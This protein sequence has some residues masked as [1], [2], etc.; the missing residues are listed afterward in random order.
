LPQ[1][2]DCTHCHAIDG[3]TQDATYTDLDAARFVSDFVP[4]SKPQCTECHTAQAA[5]NACQ[6]C[7]NYHV[8][9]AADRKFNAAVVES[10]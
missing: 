4:I 3:K 10:R 7:H 1:L 9:R 5:G 6:Q 8:E 2:A